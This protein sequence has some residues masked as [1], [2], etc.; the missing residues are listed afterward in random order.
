MYENTDADVRKVNGLLCP[1]LKKKLKS[2]FGYVSCPGV[3]RKR[4]SCPGS[5]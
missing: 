3:Y 4:V 1:H 2:S 5:S